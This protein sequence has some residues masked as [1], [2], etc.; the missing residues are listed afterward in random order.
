MEDRTCPSCKYVFK[1]PC[2]LKT[3]LKTALHCLMSEDEFKTYSDN[4][5]ISCKYC[6]KIFANKRN[7]ERHKTETKCGKKAQML[8]QQ[9]QQREQQ[10]QQRQEQEQQRLEQEREQEQQRQQEEMRKQFLDNLFGN[11]NPDETLFFKNIIAKMPGNKQP[12]QQTQ[13][14]EQQ[15]N[16]EEQNINQTVHNEGNINNLQQAQQIN[17]IENHNNSRNLTIINNNT[18]NQHIMPFGYEDVRKIPK[19]EMLRILKSGNNAGLEIIKA[20]Y[21]KM[22]N[23]NYFKHNISRNDISILSKAYDF[24]IYKE[25]EFA[26]TMFNRCIC[27][28]HHILYLCKDDL[29]DFEIQ[30]IYSNIEYI[31]TVMRKEIYENGLQNIISS[32][33]RNLN[34][35]NRTAITKYINELQ[36]NPEV[37][38]EALNIVN[39]IINLND[40][41][42]KCLKPSISDEEINYHLGDPKKAIALKPEN[43][44][45]EFQT[46]QF[47]ES[48]YNLFW[49]ERLQEEKEFFENHEGKTIGDIINFGKRREKIYKRLETIQERHR[50]LKPTDLTIDLKVGS[51]YDDTSSSGDDVA[52]IDDL[53]NFNELEA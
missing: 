44:I 40:K 15:P 11:L 35:F 29:A 30:D 48:Q 13:Q 51:D 7:L 17:N 25:K 5:N 19:P 43:N 3:H 31:S 6:K 22:E 39:E 14:E 18:I 16:N 50:E 28:L 34:T 32:E 20:V 12:Q 46:N 24:Q 37:K 38:E 8:E 2:L 27:L 26:D 45:K 33:I 4:I 42:L 41:V 49:Q 36:C 23:K 47:E 10:E 21:S 9:R 53:R 1:Y 52:N